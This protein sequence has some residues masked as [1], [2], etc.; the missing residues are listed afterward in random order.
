MNIWIAKLGENLSPL[1]GPFEPPHRAISL[2]RDLAAEGHEV[3]YWTSSMN[4][5]LKRQRCR[6]SAITRD[7][8]GVRIAVLWAPRYQINISARRLLH[9]YLA[10]RQFLSVAQKLARPDVILACYPPGDICS[11]GRKFARARDIPFLIDARDMWPDIFL[12]RIPS[13]CRKAAQ[14]LMYPLYAQARRCF[15]SARAI[16]GI[17]EG[18][19]EWAVERAG[20]RR[21]ANDTAFPLATY[22]QNYSHAI[23]EPARMFWRKLLP[24][25]DLTIIFIG[26]LGTHLELETLLEAI[27][28]LK[29]YRAITLVLAGTGENAEALQ[30]RYRS[31]KGLVF[32]GWVDGPKIRA[33][34]EIADLGLLPYPS[35]R[36]F[37]RSIPN[38]VGE[39]LSGGVPLLSSLNGVLKDFLAKWECGWTYESGQP[40]LLADLLSSLGRERDLVAA[41]I[42]AEE[43]F[44][45]E[46]NAEHVY[47]AMA[48]WVVSFAKPAK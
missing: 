46:L 48:K 6:E 10:S 37:I 7:G 44:K 39:Y 36:D 13:S 22:R 16:T 8:A 5:L 33:L 47:N 35:R 15:A 31:V 20:R 45:K 18:M 27:D 21:T 9:H 1:D 17:T 38:K 12:D 3:T 32:P 23:L 26:T 34:L 29:P 4:H 42:R 11:A 40:R 19:V 30:R 25:S 28:L 2:A 41:R 14:L 43:A 24:P